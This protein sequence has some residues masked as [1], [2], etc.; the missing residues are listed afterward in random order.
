VEPVAQRERFLDRYLPS[1][2]FSE[3][4]ERPVSAPAL[5]VAEALQGL[6]PRDTPLSGSLLA[7]RLTPAALAA[8]SW[9][10]PRRRPWLEILVEL[11]FVELGRRDDEAAF[12]AIGKFW[13]L[14]ETLE[15]IADAESFARFDK[16]GFAKGVIDFRVMGD[17]QPVNVITETRVLA[18]DDEAL[19]RFRPYWIPVRVFG[20][21]M[22]REL[23]ASVGRRAEHAAPSS[24]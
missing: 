4:H 1:W 20:G 17:S 19:R 2:Q 9:P 23:L 10:L 5:K 22:R 6:T 7:L 13:R 3:V 16:P 21:L 24:E 8:G 14:R 11:G 18:L 15:P 12:G